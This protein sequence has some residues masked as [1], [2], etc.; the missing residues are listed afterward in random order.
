MN[1]A[2]RPLSTEIAR[3]SNELTLLEQRLQSEPAP[4]L[5]L[6]N[7]FRQSVDNIR[8]TAWTVSE[9]AHAHQS[10]AQAHKVLTFLTAERLRRLN[11]LVQSLCGEIDR[12]A[13]TFKNYGMRS[14]LSSVSDL[15]ERLMRCARE[16]EVPAPDA[17]A[18]YNAQP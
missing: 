3:L 18:R 6:L 4:D 17:P 9:L 1:D 15:H 12:H 13:V 16:E 5:V 14:L 2:P 8:L 11:Q 10:K 7:Q